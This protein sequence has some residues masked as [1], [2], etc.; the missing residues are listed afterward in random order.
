MPVKET[1]K[2][3]LVTGKY[4]TDQLPIRPFGTEY[5]VHGFVRPS[6][7]TVPDWEN[8]APSV[9]MRWFQQCVTCGGSCK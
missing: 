7:E 3:R 1:F 9:D 5:G 8:I 6:P 4:Q 2:R